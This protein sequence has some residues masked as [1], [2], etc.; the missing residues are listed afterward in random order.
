[1]DKCFG[2]QKLLKLTQEVKPPKLIQEEIDNLHS[3]L[4]SQEVNFIIKKLTPKKILGPDDF[5]GGFYHTFKEEIILNLYKHPE[6]RKGRNT[7]QLILWQHYPDS[8]TR[9]ISRKQNYRPVTLK[10]INAKFFKNVK[11]N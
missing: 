2:R 3:P 6:N 8:K 1:M 4:S 5:I 11:Q 10:N 9:D 7:S